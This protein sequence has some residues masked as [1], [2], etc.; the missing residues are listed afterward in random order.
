MPHKMHDEWCVAG[1]HPI[2]FEKDL[3]RQKRAFVYIYSKEMFA[4]GSQG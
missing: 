3:Q 2:V 4:G 1:C